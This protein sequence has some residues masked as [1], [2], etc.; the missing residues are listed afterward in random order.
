MYSWR[1]VDEPRPIVRAGPSESEALRVSWAWRVLTADL[2]AQW[3]GV[4]QRRAE[5]ILGRLWGAGWLMY[6]RPRLPK[7]E[8]T[9]P[10]YYILSS[11][12]ARVLE[13]GTEGKAGSKYIEPGPMADPGRLTH[14]ATALQLA[15]TLARA[16]GVAP[17]GSLVGPR[18]SSYTFKAASK[19]AWGQITPDMVVHLD[20][21]AVLVEY[22]RNGHPRGVADKITNYRQFLLGLSEKAPWTMFFPVQPAILFIGHKSGSTPRPGSGHRSQRARINQIWTSVKA[23]GQF[24]IAAAAAE[25][26]LEGSPTVVTTD[27]RKALVE[28]PGK[29]S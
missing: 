19:Q 15:L 5:V 3:L 29:A 6:L 16:W 8:G 2:L 14:D 9:S 24:Q 27:G 18:E 28:W 21:V 26:L 17:T 23:L 1:R 13:A 11:E 12:G 22:E 20:H 4:T 10:R 25:E 7:G